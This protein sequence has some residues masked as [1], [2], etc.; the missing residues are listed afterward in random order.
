MAIQN[1]DPNN[2]RTQDPNYNNVARTGGGFG[3]WWVWVVIV[4]AVFW[5][6]GW[7]FGS[8][9]GWWWGGRRAGI[10]GKSNSRINGAPDTAENSNRSTTGANNPSTYGAPP[11]GAVSTNPALTHTTGAGLDVL[12]S[13]DKKA[14]VGR[15]FQVQNIPVQKRVKSNVVWVGQSAGNRILVVTSP[16]T[17]ETAPG[18]RTGT[19][20]GA[21]NASTANHKAVGMPGTGANNSGSG[22]TGAM[23]AGAT[24]NG[25]NTDLVNVQG[26]VE[27][28]PS[29]RQAKQQWGLSDEGAKRL[30]AEGV[31]VAASRLQPVQF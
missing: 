4:I 30:E 10:V 23:T 1:R 25:A 3:W 22:N 15:T 19:S 29:A 5:F 28:A 21:A 31:Y 24:N 26:K 14:F 20:A 8:Y 27:K 13:T 9:G 11:N 6:V 18:N 12:N 16:S 17:D 2:P 7:G